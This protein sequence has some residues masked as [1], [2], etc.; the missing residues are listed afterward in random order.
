MKWSA[1]AKI[2]IWNVVTSIDFKQELI[3]KSLETCDTK[4]TV[5]CIRH[6]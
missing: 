4:S 2:G 1:E 5:K 6:L 3:G